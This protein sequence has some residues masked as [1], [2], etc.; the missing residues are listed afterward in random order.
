MPVFSSGQTSAQV[1]ETL[2]W[3]GIVIYPRAGGGIWVIHGVPQAIPVYGSWKRRGRCHASVMPGAYSYY[4]D[5]FTGSTDVR[6]LQSRLAQRVVLDHRLTTIAADYRLSGF[7]IAGDSRMPLTRMD[8]EQRR[9]SSRACSPSRAIVLQD[10][11]RS[12][13]RRRSLHRRAMEIRRDF[14]NSVMH[15]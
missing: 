11:Q 1:P 4:G 8:G 6:R 12:T 9:R 2:A 7:G 15:W 10:R 5:D 3:P 13:A 14:S